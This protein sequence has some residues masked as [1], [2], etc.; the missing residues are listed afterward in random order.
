[1]DFALAEFRHN[2]IVQ[3]PQ[4]NYFNVCRQLKEKWGLVNM[5][6]YVSS[7]RNHASLWTKLQNYLNSTIKYGVYKQLMQGV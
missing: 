5:T 6:I 2:R 7:G 4:E 1:M 3:S